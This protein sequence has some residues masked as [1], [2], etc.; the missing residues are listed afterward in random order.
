MPKNRP[1]SK[2]PRMPPPPGPKQKPRN[3]KTVIPQLWS[4]IIVGREG[5]IQVE[6]VLLPPPPA[7]IFRWGNEIL[8]ELYVTVNNDAIELYE[9]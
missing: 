8:P 4:R 9:F 1:R 2:P 6:S 7:T 3:K 5:G